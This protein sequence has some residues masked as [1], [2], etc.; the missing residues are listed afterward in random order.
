MNKLEVNQVG[1]FPMTTRILDEIQKAHAV[2]NSLGGLAGNF[3]IIAGCVTVGSTVGDG[4]VFINGEVFDFKGGLAQ[5]KVIIKEVVENL[6]FQ[7]GNANPVIKTR[8][9]TFGTGV[10]A[11]NWADFKRPIET[12]EISALIQRIEDL[13]ARPLVGNIPIGLIAIW[14]QAANLIPVGWEEYTEL[15]GRVPIG[16]SND[17]EFDV[18]GKTGGAKSKTLSVSEMPEHDHAIGNSRRNTGGGSGGD[19]N[20]PTSFAGTRDHITDKQGS[21]TA[22]SIMNPFRVVHFIKYKG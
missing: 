14:G 12:K 6:T 16:F 13:E 17:A 7:N 21:G 3:T 8:Y 15:S 19:E 20:H 18:V 22:F 5:S 10:G 4:F 2:F 1:G 9:V 11:F